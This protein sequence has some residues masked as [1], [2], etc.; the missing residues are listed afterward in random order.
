MGVGW[1][2]GPR[3]NGGQQGERG[4]GQSAPKKAV[5]F[6]ASFAPFPR[7]RAFASRLWP[8]ISLFVSSMN[9]NLEFSI[10]FCCLW[11]FSKIMMV[12]IHKS[13][14][15]IAKRSEESDM[16]ES[17]F[18]FYDSSFLSTATMGQNRVGHGKPLHQRPN[19][20]KPIP[21]KPSHTKLIQL[22]LRWAR[23]GR[24]AMPC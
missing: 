14:N 15:I 11:F 8:Q 3:R 24:N 10:H 4:G 20:T 1:G 16:C 12:N 18:E 13:M 22:K 6:L 5:R 2:V 19:Q 7:P 9:L 23:S 21:T 17:L